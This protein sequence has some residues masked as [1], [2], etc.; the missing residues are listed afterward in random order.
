MSCCV[1]NV[2]MQGGH[3]MV[4]DIDIYTVC[5]AVLNIVSYGNAV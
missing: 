2:V 4:L 5:G 1:E 3:V